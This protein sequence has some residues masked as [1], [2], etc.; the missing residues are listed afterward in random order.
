VA[1]LLSKIQACPKG[2]VLQFCEGNTKWD[3][4]ESVR[5]VLIGA[6]RDHSPDFVWPNLSYLKKA[7]DLSH[8][9]R[10]DRTQVKRVHA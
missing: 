8:T 3:E 7:G 10:R 1:S 9:S 4:A 5:R 2:E 6:I